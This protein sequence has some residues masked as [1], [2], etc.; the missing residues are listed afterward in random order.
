MKNKKII[1]LNN[2]ED[3]LCLPIYELIKYNKYYKIKQVIN[4][5]NDKIK[6]NVNKLCYMI[7]CDT[8]VYDYL[9]PNKIDT[10]TQVLENIYILEKKENVNNKLNKLEN[11][12]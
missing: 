2:I 10:L 1:M 4:T 7:P 3:K 11:K 5:N 6:N 12:H 8:L 9:Y